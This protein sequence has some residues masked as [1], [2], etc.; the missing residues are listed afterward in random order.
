MKIFLFD[1]LSSQ[2]ILLKKNITYLLISLIA[3]L[4][5]SIMK[6]IEINYSTNI[7]QSVNT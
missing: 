4:I 7:L 3:I 5:V 2:Q 6:N 1:M